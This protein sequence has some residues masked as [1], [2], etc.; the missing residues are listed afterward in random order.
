MMRIEKSHS[1]L[2]FWR[3]SVVGKICSTLGDLHEATSGAL[4]GRCWLGQVGVFNG[5]AC[6]VYR[7]FVMCQRL[8]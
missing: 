5:K 8:L 3:L 7:A 2:A 4:T 6:Y 1:R